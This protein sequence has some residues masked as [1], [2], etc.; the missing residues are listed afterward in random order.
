MDFT[1]RMTKDKYVRPKKTLQDKLTP[2][3]IEEKLEDYI[4]I[5]TKDLESVPLNTHIRYFSITTDKKTGKTKKVFRLGGFL[6]KKNNYEKYIVL[7]NRSVTWSV[8]TQTSIIY[9][10]MNIK[11]I[12]EQ[13]EEEIKE[14]KEKVIKYKN[15][16]KKYKAE[17][18]K[19]AKKN[20]K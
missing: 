4:E 12:K 6:H 9:K 11:E 15:E 1:N 16:V 5:E 18:K 14:L 2:E 20:E 19:L 7:T 3:E 10:I 8:N 17:Y 13:Y